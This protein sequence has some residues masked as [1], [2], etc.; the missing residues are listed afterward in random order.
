MLNL[1]YTCN[2]PIFYLGSAL[3]SLS[4]ITVHLAKLRKNGTISTM[5]MLIMLIIYILII[6]GVSRLI[7][8]CCEKDYNNAAWVIALL[9]ILG[10]LATSFE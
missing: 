3:I 4:A 2:Q 6:Y 9:P 8:W 1:H 7:N 10:V 5:N